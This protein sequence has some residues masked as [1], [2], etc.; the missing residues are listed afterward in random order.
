V[1]VSAD[2]TAAANG[3]VP[4]TRTFPISGDVDQQPTDP[5]QQQLRHAFDLLRLSLILMLAAISA[6]LIAH[7][8]LA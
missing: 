3:R 1:C 7:I 2:N 6:S 8:L 4:T 5:Q